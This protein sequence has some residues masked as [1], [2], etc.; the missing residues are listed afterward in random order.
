MKDKWFKKY[1]LKAYFETYCSGIFSD[2][3][4]KMGFRLQ[5]ISGWAMN[6]P[7]LRMFGRV[8]TVTLET[9]ETNDECI[10]KGLGFHASLNAG[11]VLV[12]KGSHD[13]AYFGE[14]MTRLSLRKELAGTIIDGLTRD[15]YYTQG[16]DYPIFAK[17]YTPTDIKGRG[18]VSETDVEIEV[19]GVV[20]KPNDFVFGDND[21]VVVIPADQIDEAVVHFNETAKQEEDTKKMIFDGTSIDDILRIVKEF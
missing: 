9:I 13:Y 14:L 19:D 5:V 17:G 3:L 8:R 20:L 21:A 12:V 15:S 10:A 6:N 1:L 2:E 4:D 18:R 7:R 11:D 16:V